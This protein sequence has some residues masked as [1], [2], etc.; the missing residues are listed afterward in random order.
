MTHDTKTCNACGITKPFDDFG[1]RQAGKKMYLRTR[2]KPCRAEEVRLARQK[3]PEEYRARANATR[4]AYFAK[5]PEKQRDKKL[6]YR[7]NQP[8]MYE[9]KRFKSKMKFKEA[10][11][12]WADKKVMAAFY[13]VAIARRAGGEDVT[14]DHVIPLNHDLV[15]GLHNEFNLQYLTFDENVAKSNSFEIE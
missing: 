9:V 11:P 4:A 8:G 7:A 14:V 3:N 2:C 6:K 10:M 13:A 5:Y 12:A 15:C 1:Y